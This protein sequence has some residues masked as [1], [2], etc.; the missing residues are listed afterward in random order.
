MHTEITDST[1][2]TPTRKVIANNPCQQN[3]RT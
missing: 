1:P 3:F 2:Q